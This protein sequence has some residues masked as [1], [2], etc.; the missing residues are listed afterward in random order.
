MNT[1]VNTAV[2]PAFS[3]ASAG[4]HLVAATAGTLSFLLIW[5]TTVSGIA[6]RNGWFGIKV[7]HSSLHGLHMIGASTGLVLGLLH[8]F[9]QLAAP[10]AKVR[11]VDVLVPF[12]NRYD[13]VGIGV[14]V[15][16][17]E[18]MVAAAVS[19]ALQRRLGFT[20]WRLLH[21][22]NHIAFMLL[23][24]HILIS[25]SDVGP[26]W[27]WLSVL[28]LWLVAVACWLAGATAGRWSDGR[29]P[30]AATRPAVRVE[31][32]AAS[33]RRF[34]FCEHEAPDVFRLRSD[35]RLAY[36]THVSQ[37]GSDAVLRAATACPVRAILVRPVQTQRLTGPGAPPDPG[38]PGGPGAA[39]PT[40]T[41]GR[42]R[43]VP[44]SA[45]DRRRT[46]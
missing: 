18:I 28:G 35:G 19:V 37:A 34:G 39:D 13:P 12:G 33:C 9:A 27:V 3:Q 32:D 14:G 42:G 41:D 43:V 30:A 38:G 20:R 40:E 36:R 7:R 23:V 29:G 8:G 26:P 45:A 25:G 46:R 2:G 5:L 10:V 31:V 44:L 22:L 21:N 11:P 1:A 4:V 17:L 24:A 6:L 15:L 16:G